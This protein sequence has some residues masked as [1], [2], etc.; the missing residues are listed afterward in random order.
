M[1]PDD[2]LNQV[3]AR[4][5]APTGALGPG[6]RVH[7][8]LTPLIQRWARQH[9][10]E[11]KIS[12]SYAKETAVRGDTDVDLFISMR[13]SVPGT[14]ADLY[15]S[16]GQ[17]MQRNGYEVRWQ[18]V[19]IGIS[20]L[21]LKVDLV[22][23]RQQSAWTSNHSIYISKRRTWTL[24]NVDTHIRNVTQSGRQAEI[25]LLKRWRDIHQLEAPSF[26][27]ELSALRALRGRRINNL[28]PNVT[29]C[30]EFLRDQLTSTVLMDPANTNNNVADDMTA[31]EK[32][33]AGAAARRSLEE[34]N[35]DQIIW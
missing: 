28:A 14:L 33:E 19:S 21:G 4:I 29:L 8:E 27:L 5:R 6:A 10:R 7:Q 31:S 20:Y 30:L 12:G 23:G 11:V 16:L 25:C 15:K 9:L 32:R 13:S 22:P 18:H 34:R 1:T 3:L 26:C 35:W 2:Y 17:F 24:T